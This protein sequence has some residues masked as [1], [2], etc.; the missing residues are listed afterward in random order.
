MV[1]EEHC[2]TVRC[3]KTNWVCEEKVCYTPYTTCKMVQE[4]CLRCVP[5]TT[6]KMEPYCTTYQT[7]R[8]VPVCEPVCEPVCDPCATPVA[9]Q[10]KSGF[11]QNIAN[12]C[13]R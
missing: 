6:C 7:C 2:R 10:W 4:T 5:K 11:F 1:P 13:G 3:C 9:T 12:C 8:M